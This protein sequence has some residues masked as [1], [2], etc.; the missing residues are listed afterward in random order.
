VVSSA[1]GIQQSAG[2]SNAG[3]DLLVKRQSGSQARDNIGSG[4]QEPVSKKVHKEEKS[5]DNYAPRQ[6]KPKNHKKQEDQ[7][8]KEELLTVNETQNQQQNH[9]NISVAN[10]SFKN[11]TVIPTSKIRLKEEPSRGVSLPPLNSR[12]SLFTIKHIDYD[13]LSP[14]KNFPQPPTKPLHVNPE[15][16]NE[17][18]SD[19]YKMAQHLMKPNNNIYPN[20][21]ENYMYK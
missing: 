9:F 14:K 4:V 18:Q 13:D 7:Q 3:A 21:D 2:K 6:S 15:K 20:L 10:T 11:G 5:H 12:S 17:Q 16:S 1:P 8:V 19:Y